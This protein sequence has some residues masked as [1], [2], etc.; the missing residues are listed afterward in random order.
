MHLQTNPEIY[1]QEVEESNEVLVEEKYRARLDDRPKLLLVEDNMDMQQ[2]IQ[3]ILK[4]DYVI[5]TA[6]D[7]QEGLDFLQKDA[8]DLI[9]SDVMMP[10]MDGITFSQQVKQNKAWSHIPF[11]MLTAL[12]SESDRI[13]AL[14]TGID[15]YLTKPFVEEE[16]TVRLRNIEGS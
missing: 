12:N 14:R 7:G 10:R 8:Y 3:S 6:R 1:D 9:I 5:D 2:Y 11:V 13:Y 15:D 16:L 4:D